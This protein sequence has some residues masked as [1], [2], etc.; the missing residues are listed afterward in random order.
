MKKR[1]KPI[2][3]DSLQYIYQQE[4]LIGNIPCDGCLVPA[5]ATVLTLTPGPNEINADWLER[6]SVNRYIV[7]INLRS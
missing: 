7:E 5:E 1:L 4:D 2:T 6:P 3:G